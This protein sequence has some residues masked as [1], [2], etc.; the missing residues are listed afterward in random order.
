MMKNGLT[1]ELEGKVVSEPYI[2]MTLSLMNYF[3]VKHEKAEHTI[4]VSHQSYQPKDIFIESDWSAA[5]YYYELAAFAENVNLEL[6]G[7]LNHSFQGDAVI[8]SMMNSFGVTTSFIDEKITMR[9]LEAAISAQNHFSLSDYPDLAPAMFVTAGG[10]SKEISFSGLE[11]LAYKESH[12]EEALRTE[13]AKCGVKVR[14]DSGK[15]IVSGNFKAQHPRFS[16]YRD[17]RMAMSLAPLAMLCDE[18]LIEDPMVVNKSYPKYW[19]DLKSLGFEI[20][21]VS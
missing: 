13:L 21:E 2:N 14:N 8:A 11:H 3:E 10:L 15:I 1:I 18:V 6:H 20:N 12:R 7:L 5:S 19:D 17:H 4:H 9:K 16:T